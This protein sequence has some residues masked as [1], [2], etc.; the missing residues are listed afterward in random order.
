MNLA[1]R[2]LARDWR[3]GELG[4]LAL[5]ITLAVTAISAVAFFGERVKGALVRDSHQLLGGDMLLTADQPWDAGVANDARSRGLTVA[6]STNFISMAR[7]SDGAQLASVKAVSPEYP[8]R[9]RLRIADAPLAADREAS[10]IP[11]RGTVWIDERLLGALE[12]DVGRTIELGN[13]TFSIGALVTVEPDR[14]VSFFN[15]APRILMHLEDVP[16]TGLI[17]VG[18]RVTYQLY[19]AGPRPVVEAFEASLKPRLVRGQ[20]IQSLANARPEVRAALERAEQFLGL[21]ALLAVIL[22]AV[23]I[24]LATRRYVA[25]HLDGYAVMR[26]LGASHAQLFRTCAGEFIGLALVA[27][28]AGCALG[29]AGQ[30]LIG[31][32]MS[33]VM[34]APL[35]L[36]GMAPVAQG[37][38]AGVVLLAGFAL[39]PLLA[40]RNVPALRVIRRD[41]PAGQVSS[42]AAYG[43]ALAALGVLL[44]WQAGSVRLGLTVLGGFAAALAVFGAIAFGLIRG[45]A[46][47]DR[48][49]PMT[50]RLGLANLRRRGGSSAVQVVALAVGLMAMLMLTFTRA[51][52]LDAWRTKTPVDAPNRFLLNIQ[53]DQRAPVIDFF[54]DEKLPVPNVWPM[55]RGRLMAIN[56]AAIDSGA[57]D[58]RGKRLVERE[59]NL[60][61]MERLPA[62]NRVIAGQWFDEAQLAKG[63]ASIEEGIAKTLGVKL[64]DTLTWSIGGREVKSPVTSVRKLDWDSM[65][66]NF[67]VIMTPSLLA[68]SPTSFITSFHLVDAQ[69]ASMHRLARQFPNLTIVDMTAILRQAL[70]V[71]EQVIRAVQFVFLFAL[72]AGLLVLYAALIATQDERVQETAIMRALGAS[73]AQVA[74]SQRMEFLLMGALA[75]LLAAGGAS[76]VGALLATQV[77]Q[78][79][80][81]MNLWVWIAGPVAGALLCLW[82]ARAG[83]RAAVRF[84]P[85]VALRES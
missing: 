7:S 83:A 4:I 76:A 5:A 32:W 59:F 65:Q 46:R 26:C 74:S 38:F 8:L 55:V 40:L 34:R 14:G 75:G 64:G 81:A 29:F 20:G 33:E 72:G 53:P 43:A 62:H 3:A 39:P 25:R 24:G 82:N 44:V 51:D 22:S 84:P 61:Y 36:P 15:I 13:A 42:V 12:L 69:A 71:M 56:D 10:G 6:A 57:L 18:S 23:A 77:F 50:V 85:I 21:T 80:Y 60:S 19:V 78:L 27:S 70:T 58:D 66:V 79:Q 49:V 37:L 28:M 63:A 31:H 47:L 35:P 17:Q 68:E 48:L 2:F 41:A 11:P 1:W 52:L 45:T 16:A 9:G 30:F 67:F 73:R 54:A